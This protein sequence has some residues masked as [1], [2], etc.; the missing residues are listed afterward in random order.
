MTSQRSVP[1]LHWHSFASGKHLRRGSERSARRSS[2][3]QEMGHSDVSGSRRAKNVG[4]VER[5]RSLIVLG[6]GAAYE[7]CGRRER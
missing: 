3:E 4:V 5:A 7:A 6:C 2:P 1:S